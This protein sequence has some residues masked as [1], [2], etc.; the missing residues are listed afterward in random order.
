MLLTDLFP[1]KMTA[2]PIPREKKEL[3]QERSD[4]STTPTCQLPT[5]LHTVYNL[6]SSARLR[7]TAVFIVTSSPPVQPSPA[8]CGCVFCVSV[9]VLAPVQPTHLSG[10]SIGGCII[11]PSHTPK[12]C[13]TY[14]QKNAQKN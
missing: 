14:A 6:L 2:K 11:P 13:Y 4:D 9:Y 10:E 3:L 12:I 1:G 8:V 7:A 5:L